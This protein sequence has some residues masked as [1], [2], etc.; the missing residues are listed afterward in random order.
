MNATFVVRPGGLRVLY[1]GVPRRSGLSSCMRNTGTDL[2]ILKHIQRSN[3]N[4]DAWAR[5]RTRFSIL[6]EAGE[7]ADSALN[8]SWPE[9]TQHFP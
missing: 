1:N 8:A 4:S 6:Y 2:E 9:N 3:S 5:I 7:A